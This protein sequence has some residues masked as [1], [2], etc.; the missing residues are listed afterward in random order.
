MT[1]AFGH[2]NLERSPTRPTSTGGDIL[3]IVTSY[4]SFILWTFVY[5]YAHI[6]DESWQCESSYL[7]IW[8]GRRKWIFVHKQDPDEPSS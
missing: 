7:L 4:G 2:N 5:E 8:L 6:G 3:R 1:Q